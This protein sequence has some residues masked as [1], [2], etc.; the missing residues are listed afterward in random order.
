M[1]T[2]KQAGQNDGTKGHSAQAEKGKEISVEFPSLAEVAER[3]L[4]REEA[5]LLMREL[6]DSLPVRWHQLASIRDSLPETDTLRQKAVYMIRLMDQLDS[7]IGRVNTCKPG[8][9]LGLLPTSIKVV[10]GCV[11][12]GEYR[13]DWDGSLMQE[14]N[15]DLDVN[16][17]SKVSEWNAYQRRELARKFERWAK[18]LRASAMI[19]IREGTQPN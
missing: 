9:Q 1:R 16:L 19:L 15:R 7:E 12:G 6:S 14:A 2:P 3:K 8:E 13:Q 10:G 4:T 17:Q 18:Q 5:G 11:L